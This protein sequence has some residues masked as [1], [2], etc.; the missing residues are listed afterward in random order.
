MR[1]FAADLA[2]KAAM[3]GGAL[4]LS[5]AQIAAYGAGLVSD[6]L[7]FTTTPSPPLLVMDTSFNNRAITPSMARR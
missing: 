5:D 7:K 2:K 1:G 4:S 3:D 6:P